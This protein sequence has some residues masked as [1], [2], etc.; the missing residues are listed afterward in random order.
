M[1]YWGIPRSF[2]TGFLTAEDSGED[3]SLAPRTTGTMGDNMKID[4]ASRLIVMIWNMQ[5]ETSSNQI[6]PVA[7]CDFSTILE[8]WL[9]GLG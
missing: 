9:R 7:A 6:E 1:D 5:H 2:E 4:E 8:A 3:T